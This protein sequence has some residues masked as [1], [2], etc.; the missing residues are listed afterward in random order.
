M[1]KKELMTTNGNK[2]ANSKVYK[3]INSVDDSFYIGSTCGSLAKR[4]YYHKSDSKKVINQNNKAYKH[5]NDIG[6]GNKSIILKLEFNLENCEQLR[7]EENTYIE[8][9]K[10]DIHCLN[11]NRAY[12]DIEKTKED[13]RNRGKTS[14]RK[15]K[16]RH[17]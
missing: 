14:T 7:R 2:Y 1:N 16:C 11:T 5:F 4:L 13:D 6:W 15:Q 8:M 9:Y 10:L 17:Y 3:L 12:R